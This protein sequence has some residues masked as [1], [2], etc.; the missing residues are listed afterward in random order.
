MDTFAQDL[1]DHMPRLRAYAI[2]LT[3]NRA[4]ADDLVQETAARALCG[5]THFLPGTNFAAWTF[6]ILHNEYINT[7][8]RAH[9]F[10]LDIDTVP[11]AALMHGPEQIDAVWERDVA[12]AMRTLDSKQRAVLMEIGVGELSYEDAARR[13]GC[14]LGTVKSRLF[15]A[16]VYMRSRFADAGPSRRH[17][18]AACKRENAS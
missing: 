14:S 17:G 1:V 8:R 10:P 3:R 6:R 15:R 13:L 5:R 9:R 16:R 4:D 18:A 11:E 12:G 7:L 2:R